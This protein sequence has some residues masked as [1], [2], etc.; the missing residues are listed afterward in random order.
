MMELTDD[1]F[2]F[3]NGPPMQT[4]RLR[5]AAGSRRRAS[6]GRGP[7][8]CAK[9]SRGRVMVVTRHEQSRSSTDTPLFRHWR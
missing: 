7:F 9:I 4:V 3:T 8:V 6:N 5:Y 1:I 2:P